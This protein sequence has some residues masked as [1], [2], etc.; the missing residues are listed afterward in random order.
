MKK[1]EITPGT[2]AVDL[3]KEQSNW[4]LKQLRKAKDKRF[5]QGCSGEEWGE[6][7]REFRAKH[8]IIAS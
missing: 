1:V 6:F 3:T 2:K 7:V 8:G 4:L 5:P